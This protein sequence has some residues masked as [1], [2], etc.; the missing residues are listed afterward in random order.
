VDFTGRRYVEIPHG[1]AAYALSKWGWR[2]AASKGANY[3]SI[4]N[5]SLGFGYLPAGSE[6]SLKV[7]GLK[8]LKEIPVPL[9]DPVIATAQGTLSVQGLVPNEHYLEYQGGQ[10]A[11][12]YDANWNKVAE[13]PVQAE[14]AMVPAKDSPITV[15][16][17]Q[18]GPLP[19]LEVQFLTRGEPIRVA[20]PGAEGP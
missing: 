3:A 20:K 11:T 5:L 2:F 9:T 17:A 16:T 6:A 1:E 19:W 10:T 12:L 18:S 4:R 13:L 14:N 15:K 8:A 7:S